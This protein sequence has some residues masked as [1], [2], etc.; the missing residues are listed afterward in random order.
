MEAEVAQLRR[1]VASH[2]CVDQAIGVLICLHQ[3]DPDTGFTVLR[4]TSQLA[5]TKLHTVAEAVTH[6]A[7]THQPLSVPIKE[8]L[9][10]ALRLH[11]RTQGPRRADHARRRWLTSRAPASHARGGTVIAAVPP[12]I[13]N[14]PPPAEYPTPSRTHPREHQPTG[15]VE[16]S[17]RAMHIPPPGDARTLA[18]ARK[19]PRPAPGPHLHTLATQIA[20]DDPRRRRNR[21]TADPRP[22]TLST[23]SSHYPQVAASNVDSPGR[24]GLMIG[25]DEPGPVRWEIQMHEPC[26]RVWICKAH[27]RTPTAVDPT[28][29]GQTVLAAY[30][31]NRPAHYGE[32]I[33][34]LV[35]T[36]T[37]NPLI[38]DA[39]QPPYDGWNIDPA[40]HEALPGYLRSALTA[41]RRSS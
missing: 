17:I 1:A 27:G 31:T 23:A 37:G 13:R 10:E 6:W 5:N 15:I 24:I 14:L 41:L 29:F 38:L 19:K 36:N 8:A 12:R 21:T 35:R 2:A 3:L 26:S 33:R 28:A 39:D 7:R 32:T 34:V 30:L 22:V 16:H 20:D 25:D 40:L 18:R 11:T 9:D 4:V